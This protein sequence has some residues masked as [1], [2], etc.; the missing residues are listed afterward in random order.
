MIRNSKKT[1]GFF[2]KVGSGMYG[3]KVADR[4]YT[5]NNLLWAAWG[6]VILTPIF[7]GVGVWVMVSSLAHAR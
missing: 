7:V 2:N 4:L 5:P 3:K 6:F 1:A